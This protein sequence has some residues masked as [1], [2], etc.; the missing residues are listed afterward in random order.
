MFVSTEVKTTTV[1][2]LSSLQQQ[3]VYTRPIYH[4]YFKEI[5]ASKLVILPNK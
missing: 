3:L 5:E 1:L 4:E 2:G